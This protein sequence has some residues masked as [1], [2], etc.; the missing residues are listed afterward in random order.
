[1]KRTN[2]AVW[3]EKQK[4]WQIKVQKDGERRTFYSFKPGRTRGWAFLF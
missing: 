3:M 1:M 2:T 4:R